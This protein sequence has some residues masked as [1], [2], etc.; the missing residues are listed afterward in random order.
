MSFFRFLYDS[1]SKTWTL[2]DTARMPVYLCHVDWFRYSTNN[3]TTEFPYGVSVWIPWQQPKSLLSSINKNDARR[4]KKRVSYLSDR[5]MQKVFLI[6]NVDHISW[7]HRNWFGENSSKKLYFL[8]HLES[9]N[10]LTE[11]IVNVLERYCWLYW[12]MEKSSFTLV[13]DRI[14]Y[15]YITH[16][17]VR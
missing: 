11:L 14:I 5:K 3:W 16:S 8:G 2:C 10:L 13:I 15:F 7:V 4:R 9:N 1:G 12:K 6:V 17:S